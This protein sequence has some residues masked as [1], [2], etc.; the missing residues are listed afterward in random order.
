M[1]LIDEIWGG[2]NDVT[3][4]NLIDFSKNHE[5]NKSYKTIDKKRMDQFVFGDKDLDQDYI[6]NSN[7]LDNLQSIQ[8]STSFTL[9]KHDPQQ[10]KMLISDFKNEKYK[11]NV[12]HTFNDLSKD[13][14]LYMNRK[15]IN[16]LKE[17]SSI[18]EDK[19]EILQ[20]FDILNKILLNSKK[21]NEENY[22]RIIK[23]KENIVT[24]FI[25]TEER[26]IY[27]YHN[28]VKFIAESNLQN[29]L[30]D[31]NWA[32]IS[33]F[34]NSNSFDSNK[35]IEICNNNVEYLKINCKIKRQ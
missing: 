2:L 31:L 4:K 24:A 26:Y 22:L 14:D 9:K 3:K 33:M 32:R 34:I 7:N 13:T 29:K 18:S 11:M 6:I 12:L 28:S 17:N 8:K 30:C 1:R 15:F 5:E 25:S 19:H 21:H 23:I 35:V 20:L 27:S 10:I 16:F